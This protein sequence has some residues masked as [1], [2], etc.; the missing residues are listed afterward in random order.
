M[1][2]G[3]GW[4]G[5]GHQLATLKGHLSGLPMLNDRRALILPYPGFIDKPRNGTEP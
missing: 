3:D 2:N 4:P 5:N 1:T